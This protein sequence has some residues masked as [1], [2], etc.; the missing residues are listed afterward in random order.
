MKKNIIVG[1]SGGPSVAINSSL[2]GVIKASGK[3]NIEK[4]YGMRNGINGLINDNIVDLTNYNNPKDLLNL[5]TTPAMVLGSC[6]I[7][8]PEI[9]QDLNVYKNIEKIFKKYNIGYFFYIGGNDSMDTVKKLTSYF[10]SINYDVKI[11]GIPKTIDND[12]VLT[13]HTPGY[14]SAAKYIAVTISELIRDTAIYN[15]KSVTIVEIMGRNSGWL[16]LAGGLPKFLGNDKPQIIALPEVAFD[17]DRFIEKINECLKVDDSVL[18]VVSEGIKDKNGNYVG[19]ET[20]SGAIDTFGHAYLSG[21]GKHLEHLV[22]QKIGC[23]VRSIEL[24]LMQRCASHMSSLA[25]I[26]SALEIGEKAVDAAINGHTGVTMGYKR[27]SNSPYK[28]EI[29]AND[30][31][32]VA[33]KEKFVPKDWTNLNNPECVKKILEY[34]LPLIKGEVEISFDDNGLPCHFVI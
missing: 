17:E 25:D 30:V 29:V 16:T 20:K 4:V 31:E 6:R 13:D 12:L 11:V 3:F 26:N 1:Q 24:N 2:A 34:I 22:T 28:Y 14:G 5:M 10:S 8:L 18:A 32:F 7:K 15:I 23:K 27:I 19:S 21:V 9:D 33:N